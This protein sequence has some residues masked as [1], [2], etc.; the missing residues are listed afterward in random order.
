MV[1][2]A[3]LYV[4]KTTNKPLKAKASNEIEWINKVDKHPM[5]ILLLYHGS[6]MKSKKKKSTPLSDPYVDN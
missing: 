2:N 6:Q 4:T 5:E 1:N 3:S